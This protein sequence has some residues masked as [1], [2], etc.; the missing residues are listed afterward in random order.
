MFDISVSYQAVSRPRPA[1]EIFV[2]TCAWE[3]TTFSSDPHIWSAVC[4]TKLY[5]TQMLNGHAEFLSHFLF[6]I[7]IIIIISSIPD[8]HTFILNIFK[9]FSWSPCILLLGQFCSKFVYP[10]G[11]M[12][13]TWTQN[14]QESANVKFYQWQVI[15]IVN[16][17]IP[18]FIFVHQS[19]YK[20][21]K[22]AIFILPQ[23]WHVS[24]TGCDYG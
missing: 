8:F 22:Y 14:G 24:A 5:N 13:M 11:V 17:D 3:I 6:Y 19:I 16:H 21:C 18:P 15:T 7:S 23:P 4:W 12:M 1:L 20:W 10:L 2:S 9:P